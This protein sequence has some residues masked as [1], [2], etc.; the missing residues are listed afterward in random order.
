M[1]AA[2]RKGVLVILDSVV[3]FVFVDLVDLI[4]SLISL[5]LS[6]RSRLLIKAKN[7]LGVSFGS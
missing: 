6:V 5:F 1:S 2:T 3:H 4:F 7:K